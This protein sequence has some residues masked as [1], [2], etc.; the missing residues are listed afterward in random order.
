M[1][2]DPEFVPS[3]RISWTASTRVPAGPVEK[4]LALEDHT[5]IYRCLGIGQV[6]GAWFVAWALTTQVLLPAE[7]LRS[8]P[9]SG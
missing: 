1:S 9:R 7:I 8:R 3:R 2:G 4:K 5:R 6:A